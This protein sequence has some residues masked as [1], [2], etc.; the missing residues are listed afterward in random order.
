MGRVAPQPFAVGGIQSFPCLRAVINVSWHKG[1]LPRQ[2]TLDYVMEVPHSCTG[3]DTDALA[4]EEA[5]KIIGGCD[6]VKEF[7]VCG[8]WPLSDG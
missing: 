7:L 2:I 4:F 1:I 6:A 5:T 3:D 8:I